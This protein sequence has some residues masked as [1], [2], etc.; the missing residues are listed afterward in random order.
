M[1]SVIKCH[2]MP[3][4][5]HF[6]VCA[7][8]GHSCDGWR[9]NPGLRRPGQ[10]WNGHPSGQTSSVYS[11]WRSATSAVPACAARCGH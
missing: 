11:M 2:S 9:T 6:I 8:I 4:D 1:C 10:L 7:L 5:G 3:V